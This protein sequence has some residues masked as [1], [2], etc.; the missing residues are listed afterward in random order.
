MS[1]KTLTF[2][3]S[4]ES[5]ATLDEIAVWRAVDH[6]EVLRDALDLYLADQAALKA[7]LEE[8]DRQI[9]AGETVSHEEVVAWFNA[10]HAHEAEAA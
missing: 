1:M 4:E 3:A 10:Q 8:A 6:A 5:V 9:E 7:D 2:E